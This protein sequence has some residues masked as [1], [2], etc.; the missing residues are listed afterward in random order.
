MS[1]CGMM[2][3]GAA[4]IQPAQKILSRFLS[5]SVDVEMLGEIGVH[6]SFGEANDFGRELN[7]GQT[8]EY[9]RKT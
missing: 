3:N 2:H 9:R 5:A 4:Q 7:E 6:F 8:R 1:S